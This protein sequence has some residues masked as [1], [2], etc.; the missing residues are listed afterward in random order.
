[1]YCVDCTCGHQ[2]ESEATILTCAHCQRVIAI[3]WPARDNTAARPT[4]IGG[5]NFR[6]RFESAAGGSVCEEQSA[7]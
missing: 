7:T 1:M 5:G 4:A 3:E 6:G 2:I